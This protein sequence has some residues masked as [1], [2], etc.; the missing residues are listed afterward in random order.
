MLIYFG[1]KF[2]FRLATPYLIRF[3]S[4]KVDERFQDMFRDFSNQRSYSNREEG[5]ISI[6]K[7]P[8]QPMKS[9][10]KVGE[11]IEYEEIE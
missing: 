2:L 3:A 8:E 10:K 4:R 11:Y 9:K 6:D 1:A 5:E 7:I